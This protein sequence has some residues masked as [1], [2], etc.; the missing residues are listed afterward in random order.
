MKSLLRRKVWKV[1]PLLVAVFVT[2]AFGNANSTQAQA[3]KISMAQQPMD[4]TSMASGFDRQFGDP[5]AL[6][7]PSALVSIF[8]P[9]AI[10]IG[11]GL[12]LLKVLIIGIWAFSR[13]QGF[14]GIGGFGGGFPGGYPGYPGGAGLGNY[15]TAYAATNQ[16]GW[17]VDGSPTGRSV[18]DRNGVPVPPFLGSTVM[19]LVDKVSQAL[20]NFEKKHGS[21]KAKE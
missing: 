21:S 15:G 11:I 1:L 4:M 18:H 8:V 16:G 5:S 20:V 10:L 7:L 2:S 3:K 6:F 19:S 17:R 14:G 12:L 13:V 9:I